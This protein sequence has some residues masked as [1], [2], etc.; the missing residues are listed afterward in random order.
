MSDVVPAPV[1]VAIDGPVGVGKSSV[2]VRLAER[3]RIPYLE[4][5]AMYR[6]VGLEVVRRGL[7]PANR[8]AV[9]ELALEID[10]RLESRSGRLE[11]LLDGAALGPEARDPLVSE[12]TSRISTYRGVRA[13][14]VELQRQWAGRS[15]AVVEG[16]DIGTKV[17]PDTPYKFFLDAALEVRV[18]RRLQQ[19]RQSGE[20]NLLRQRVERDIRRRDHRDTHRRDSPLTR[21]PSHITV[22]TST[23]TA[24]EVVERL[25]AEIH[26]LRES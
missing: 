12:V 4:T 13:R 14:L 18:E 10:L 22:D 26:R 16:R 19:L 20:H 2:A 9:E 15:G 1:I 17:F 8:Q 25:L 6:A 23:L 24:D 7:D 11:V 21:D 3:L 5:G